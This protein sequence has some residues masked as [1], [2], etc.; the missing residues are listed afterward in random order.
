MAATGDPTLAAGLRWLARKRVTLG[1][2][3][4]LLAVFALELAVWWAYGPASWGYLFLA[5]LDPSP[6]WLLAPFAHRSIEHLLTTASVVVVYGALVEATYPAGTVL[7]FYLAA[8][9]AST[10]AQLGEYVGGAP[11]LGTLG[12]S[13]AALALVALFSTT[14]LVRRLRATPVTPVEVLFAASGIVI[15]GLLLANDFLPGVRFAA[16][17]APYGHLGGVLAGLLFGLERARG[18]AG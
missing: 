5:D 4:L 10:A 8:G 18:A 7:A 15:I 12:A 3:S 13:G 1:V 17:T 9:Y 16:G 11:S 2:V 14:I 6:A